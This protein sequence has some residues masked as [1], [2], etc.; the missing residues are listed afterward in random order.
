MHLTKKMLSASSTRRALSTSSSINAVAF[1][2]AGFA[3]LSLVEHKQTHET[4]VFVRFIYL[5]KSSHSSATVSGSASKLFRSVRLVKGN[6]KSRAMMLSNQTTGNGS[7][8]P[9]APS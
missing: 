2:S 3:C 1:S 7:H 5:P 6:G 8:E 9:T 4:S